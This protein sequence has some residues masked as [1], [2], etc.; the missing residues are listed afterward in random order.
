MMPY[1]YN[2]L[3]VTLKRFNKLTQESY[4]QVAVYE[5]SFIDGEEF[6]PYKFKKST[7]RLGPGLHYNNLKGRTIKW[8]LRGIKMKHKGYNCSINVAV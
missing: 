5:S 8:C 6:L 7:Y 4:K 3:A 1:L 2:D